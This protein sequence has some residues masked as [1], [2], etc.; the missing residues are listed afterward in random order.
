MSDE[1]KYISFWRMYIPVSGEYLEISHTVR[2][3]TP[4]EHVSDIKTLL[5]LLMQ[6]GEVP[7]I[8]ELSSDEEVVDVTHYVVGITHSG[9]PAVYFYREGLKFRI[10][11]ATVWEEDFDKL[12]FK[13]EVY[14]ALAN[15][16]DL[17][18]ST[19]PPFDAAEKQGILKKLPQPLRIVL[20]D[21][22]KTGTSPKGDEYKIKKFS[23]ILGDNVPESVTNG[24]VQ[25]SDVIDD[26]DFSD[27]PEL[28]FDQISEES[29]QFVDKIRSFVKSRFGKGKW[30]SDIPE[31]LYNEMVRVATKSFENGQAVEE[32]LPYVDE[33]WMALL[34]IPIMELGKL[35]YKDLKTIIDR[36]DKESMYQ[37]AL[38][39]IA[40]L[41]ARTMEETA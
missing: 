1:R 25:Y 7:K 39:E 36:I 28:P 2:S 14:A 41:I 21:T 26:I 38:Y 22:G 3:D 32:L 29:R 8:P 27:V 31:D 10:S 24:K 6:S 37:Y 35:Q 23:H 17:A 34:G 11:G 16:K 12:P 13:D 30:S 18:Y 40:Y 5:E 15:K 19:V 9:K 33:T 4:E 20:R